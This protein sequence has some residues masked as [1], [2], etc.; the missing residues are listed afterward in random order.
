MRGF[1]T[2][3]AVPRHTGQSPGNSGLSRR[4]RGSSVLTHRGDQLWCTARLTFPYD[5]FHNQPGW[6]QLLGEIQGP[7]GRILVGLQVHIGL[8]PQLVLWGGG[9][10]EGSGAEA[11]LQVLEVLSLGVGYVAGGQWQR[12][13]LR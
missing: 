11:Q 9:G 3:T 7:L 2:N 10:K 4:G 1:N 5:S 8:Q 13:P 6:V 12:S